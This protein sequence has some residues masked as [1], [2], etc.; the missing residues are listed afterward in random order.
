LELH[1][2]ISYRHLLV[3]HNAPSDYK[4]IPPH[5]I[6]GRKIEGYLPTGKDSKILLDIMEK[7]VA[8]LEK[9]PVNIARIERGLKPANSA[10]IW[11]EGKTSSN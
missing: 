1:A 4:L 5:D 7:S 11:G 9:H 3:W 10:W 6:I 8:I 2:G